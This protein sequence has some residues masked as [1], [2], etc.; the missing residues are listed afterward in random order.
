[1]NQKNQEVYGRFPRSQ[2]GGI[3]KAIDL[4]KR[5]QELFPEIAEDY[6]NGNSLLDIVNKYGIQEEFGIK[7][8]TAKKSVSFALRGYGGEFKFFFSNKPVYTGLIDSSELLEIAKI[9]GVD[10]GK[11]LG[12]KYGSK[13]GELTFKNKTGIH[14]QTNKE[15]SNSGKKGLVSQGKTPWTDEELKT[16]YEMSFNPSYRRGIR[17]NTGKIA[18]E[19][20]SWFHNRN[21]I[22]TSFSVTRALYSHRKRKV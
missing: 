3:A 14:S 18:E 4:G 9:H 8:A 13:I 11:K 21:Q 7:E 5:I 15:K 6:R 17:V 12:G 10:S 20:N 1:M 16:A 22:R 19:I 2:I